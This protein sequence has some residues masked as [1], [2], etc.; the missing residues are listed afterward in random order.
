M[1]NISDRQEVSPKNILPNILLILFNHSIGVYEGIKTSEDVEFTL[2]S[3]VTSLSSNLS[4]HW[5]LY[6]LGIHIKYNILN[7]GSTM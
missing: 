5:I 4:P 7:V 6:D 3:I 1:F 2:R